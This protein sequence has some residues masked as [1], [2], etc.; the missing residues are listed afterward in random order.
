MFQ[1]FMMDNAFF[2]LQDELIEYDWNYRVKIC[3]NC[4]LLQKTQR[5]CFIPKEG[6]IKIMKGDVIHETHCDHMQRARTNKF[7]GRIDNLLNLA[8]F[9]QFGKGKYHK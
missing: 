2:V 8:M 3:S 4:D 5:K 6:K 1:E 7:R 9:Q